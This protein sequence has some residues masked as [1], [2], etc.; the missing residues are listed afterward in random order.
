MGLRVTKKQH[1]HLSTI[2]R[3][4]RGE[5]RLYRRARMVMLASSGESVSSVARQMGTCRSR[6]YGW[7]ERFEAEGVDG[8]SDEP[9][10]GRPVRITAL[11]RHQVVAAACKAPSEL[12]VERQVWTHESLRDAVI[13]AGLVRQIS[14][15]EVGRILEGAEL[16]PHRVR[17]WC[18]STDPDFQ[19]K[20]KAI[21]R[22]YVHGRSGEPILCIDEK[23]GM[24]ALSRSRDLQRPTPG[25]AGREEFEYRRNG[26]RSLFAC[27]NVGTGKVLGRCTRTRGR[28]DFLS[29]LDL[30]AIT[31]R[32]RKVHI[33]LDN[34]NTHRDTTAGAFISQWNE[35]HGR[36]FVFH[37]TP[38]HGSW[39]NQVELWFAIVARRVLR[40][41][42]F[43]SCDELVL[44]IE[45]FIKRWNAVEAHP[46]RWT[47]LGLPL[48]R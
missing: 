11:E 7:L 23:T 34:L 43:A 21:V 3:E 18:H 30:V 27:F 14:S 47:Y 13:E 9:R 26:T 25:R 15:S 39:L 1:E 8:L 36:R 29:F 45:R 22:L 12:G 46:F 38:T 41:A 28:K 37:Y 20:M 6:V 32:Q 48:V 17:G 44:A 40:Y 19:E 33:V 35:R 4:Q 2:I 10:S 24:Q 31:Y 42:S 5:A 16:K